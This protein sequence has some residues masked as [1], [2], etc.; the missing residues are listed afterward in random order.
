MSLLGSPDALAQAHPRK[1]DLFDEVS[2]LSEMGETSGFGLKRHH[3][4]EGELLVAGF[5]CTH[6][7]V[8]CFFLLSS[9][10]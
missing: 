2:L 6:P 1:A 7:L 4:P 3:D 5:I 8:L 10:P 9:S